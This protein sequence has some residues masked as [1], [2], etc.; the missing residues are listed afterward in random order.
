MQ[1]ATNTA[2]RWDGRSPHVRSLPGRARG[3]ASGACCRKSAAR[4]VIALGL[5]G[6]GGV[7]DLGR[8]A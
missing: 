6:C 5:L 7:V 3:W 4:P 8:G 2:V 1:D